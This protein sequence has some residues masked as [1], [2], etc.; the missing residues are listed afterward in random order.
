MD[1]LKRANELKDELVDVRR[2]LHATPEI[3]NELPNTSAYIIKKLTEYG[4]GY[5]LTG[6]GGI[7]CNIGSGPKTILVRA[8]IDALPHE[9][10]SGEPFA[11][12]NGASHSCGHDIHTAS[13][14]IAAKMLKENEAALKGTVKLLFQPD[15]ERILGAIDMIESGVLENPYVDAAISMHTCIPLKAGVFNVLPGTYLS[16]SDIFRIEISGVGSHGSA[17]EL[18]IDP[19]NIA[20]KLIDAVQTISTREV[21]AL[22]PNIITFGSVHAGDAP[23]IIPERVVLE[24]TIRCFDK[25]ARVTVVKRFEEIVAGIA[26]LY[27]TTADLT[28][29]G[30]TPVT[31]NDPALTDALVGYLKDMVGDDMVTVKSLKVKGSDDFAYFS[32]KVP[33]VMYHVGMGLAEDG[34]VNGLHN[35]KVRFDERALPNSAAAF[36]EITTRWLEDNA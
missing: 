26:A 34:Y 1:Y 29:I 33:G 19:I 22:E 7:V 12:T 3:G 10:Q 35:P 9:E 2:Y 13:M 17:P 6:K 4:C 18:G 30:Q 16:S 15:E 23:N 5:E 27:R 25:D 24:G 14:L 8:D 32:E 28:F 11:S 36:A 31:Y 21:S 20:S